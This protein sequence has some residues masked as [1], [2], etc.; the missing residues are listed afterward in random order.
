MPKE[1]MELKRKKLKNPKLFWNYI[2]FQRKCKENLPIIKDKDE[3]YT[4]NYKNMYIK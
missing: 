4:D 1:T 2:N 3:M